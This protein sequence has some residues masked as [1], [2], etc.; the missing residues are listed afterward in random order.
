LG[1]TA[2]SAQAII[3]VPNGPR[4]REFA[5]T[6]HTTDQ[7]YARSIVPYID[8]VAGVG[9]NSVTAANVPAAPVDGAPPG[10]ANNP[11]SLDKAFN[12][13]SYHSEPLTER[14][15]LTSN[16][17]RPDLATLT[18]PHDRAFSS[19]T[20]GDPDTPVTRA[21]AGDPVIFRLG[22][23]ASDQFHTFT[24][25]GHMYPLEPN[26]W[27]DASD[28]RSQLLTSR[29]ITAGEVIDAEVVGGAGGP[30]QFAGDYLYG[31]GRQPFA[32]AGMWGIFRVQPT[33][34]A[35]IAPL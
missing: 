3:R 14:L 12:H 27:T 18:A 9:V 15:G 32:Q 21:F 8:W 29:T 13:V 19:V 34:S 25:S 5:L 16:P 33:G 2:T 31:D 30:Q 7:Q 6:L 22:V 17:S 28:H 35:G 23:P 1:A 10:T 24:L 26:M 4:F 20:F 11:G